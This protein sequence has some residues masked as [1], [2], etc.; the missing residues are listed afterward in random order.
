MLW[1]PWE[2]LTIDAI[3][4]ILASVRSQ[5]SGNSVLYWRHAILSFN[6]NSSG[7][8]RRYCTF[9]VYQS[10]TADLS[11]TAGYVSLGTSAELKDHIVIS[12]EH[13]LEAVSEAIIAGNPRDLQPRL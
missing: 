3:R 11:E 2:K 10:K 6:T 8:F 4:S 13:L 1:R 7:C 9:L 5:V 12:P